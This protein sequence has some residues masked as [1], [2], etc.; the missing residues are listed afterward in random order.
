MRIEQRQ[1]GTVDVLT[2]VGALVDDDAEAFR[3]KLAQRIASPNCRVV[4]SLQEVPYMD[5][6]ALEG[7][8]D[9]ANELSDRASA[10]K[11]ANLSPICRETL[12]LTGLGGKFRLFKD[13]E[14]AVKSF[15]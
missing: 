3:R 8:V 9:A 2:P 14:D 6:A 1:V 11:L 13:V 12:E 15:L 4:I 7:L 10:L 5:S